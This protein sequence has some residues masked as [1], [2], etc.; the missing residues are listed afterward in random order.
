MTKPTAII[1]AI[2]LGVA[3]LALWWSAH[4]PETPEPSQH[5]AAQAPPAEETSAPPLVPE[6]AAPEPLPRAKEEP[7]SPLEQEPQPGEVSMPIQ[8][9]LVAEPLSEV[10]HEVIGAWDE[11][12]DSPR[13]GSHRTFVAVVNPG[14]SDSELEALL[15]D[16]RQRNRGAEVLDVRVYDSAEAARRPSYLDGGALR[17]RHLVAEIKRNDRLSFESI[18]IRGAALER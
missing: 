8:A 4:P 16:I 2:I 11:Q 10:P 7:A 9:K 3:A 15:R 14:I 18:E 6:I 1:A 12:P 13:P 5:Q 17:Q